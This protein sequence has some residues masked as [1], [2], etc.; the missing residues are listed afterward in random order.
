[1]Q[2]CNGFET[3]LGVAIHEKLKRLDL[4]DNKAMLQVETFVLGQASAALTS[5]AVAN[6]AIAPA[7]GLL[8]VLANCR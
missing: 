6:Q 8:V 3:S 2:I 7:A 1:M 5:D 4:R